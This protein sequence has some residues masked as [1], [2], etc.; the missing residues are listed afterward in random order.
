MA[1]FLVQESRILFSKYEYPPRL[2]FIQ[3]FNATNSRL[4]YDYHKT[5]L[6]KLIK[7]SETYLDLKMIQVVQEK[8]NEGEML[9][10]WEWGYRERSS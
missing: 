6:W 5:T 1:Y 4:H 9:D 10:K 2:F 8:D 7:M 3:Y